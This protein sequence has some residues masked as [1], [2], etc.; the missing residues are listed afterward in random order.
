[1]Y[2]G[3]GRLASVARAKHPAVSYGYDALGR[4]ASRTVD[5]KTIRF[6]YE[7]T[8]KVAELAAD[9]SVKR[10]FV[11]GLGD[12]P[13]AY[14]KSGRWTFLHLD[15]RRTSCAYTDESGALVATVELDPWGRAL[16]TSGDVKGRPVF[17]AGRPY[18]P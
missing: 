2:D 10:S 11:Y 14:C 9:D 4:V 17:F 16:A 8:N 3:L 1:E 18:D 5:G 6:V 12:E 15:E 7:D 13:L